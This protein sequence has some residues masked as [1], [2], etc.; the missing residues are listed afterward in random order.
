M[1]AGRRERLGVIFGGISTEHEVSVTSARSILREADEE[2]FDV[3]PRV[4]MLSF[5]NFGSVR[6]DRAEK[7]RRATD[8]VRTW[9][10]ELDIEGEVLRVRFALPRGAFA[11]VLLEELGLLVAPGQLHVGLRAVRVCGIV[12]DEVLER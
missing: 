8:L 1:S 2:R 3:V 11:T 6:D 12:Q 5:S 10:P 9:R 4:A 7:V